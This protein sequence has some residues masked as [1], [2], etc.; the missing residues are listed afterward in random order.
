[1]TPCGPGLSANRPSGRHCDMSAALSRGRLVSAAMV[2]DGLARLSNMLPP[3]L[4]ALLNL[5]I[6]LALALL[7][8]PFIWHGFG[9]A[10]GEL[11]MGL[12]LLVLA[13]FNLF[14]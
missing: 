9:G 4:K 5:A 7:A 2:L 14:T 12:G 8:A 13:V 3:R 10:W 6:T 11:A 1:M